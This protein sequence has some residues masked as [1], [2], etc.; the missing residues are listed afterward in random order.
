V[1][2]EALA[3]KVVIHCQPEIGWQKRRAVFFAE[4]FM[5]K[6]IVCEVT[7]DRRRREGIP[8]LLG[9]TLWRDIEATGNYLLVDRC[10]FGDTDKFVSLVWNGH[11]RRG[12]HRVPVSHSADRWERHGVDLVPWRQGGSRVV[13][14]G[15]VETYSQRY[16]R[17]DDW[18]KTVKATHFRPHPSG[19]SEAPYP[20]AR[21]FQDCGLAVTL[22]SSVGVQCVLNGIPTVTMDEGSMAWSVTGHSLEDVRLT[23]REPWCHWLAWTQWSD[24]EIREGYPWDFL[25]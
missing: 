21:D 16:A 5:K 17:P 6:G 4:G 12:D 23:D 1:G 15:Q 20:I 22:N 11:G 25:L 7:A 13:L 3:L 14:C 24:D 2:Q 19:Y 10:S 9:T 8:I 18:Y